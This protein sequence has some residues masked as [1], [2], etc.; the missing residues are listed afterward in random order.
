MKKKGLT[1]IELMIALSMF[2]IISLFMYRTFFTQ[3]RQAA[4]YNHNID[5][6]YN[7]NKAL[8]ML[9]DKIRSSSGITLS[10]NPVAQVLSNGVVVID[11]TSNTTSPDIYFNSGKKELVNADGRTC[12]YIDSVVISQGTSPDKEDELI[13]ITVSAVKGNSEFSS[14]TAVNIRR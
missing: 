11:L 9:T 3:I 1:L 13:Y 7:A 6:L 5:L 2:S 4:E 12:S 10:G 14:S 8:N